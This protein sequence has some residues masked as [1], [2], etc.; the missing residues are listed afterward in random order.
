MH[1]KM[2]KKVWTGEIKVVQVLTIGPI[3]IKEYKE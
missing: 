3:G 2:M 1:W